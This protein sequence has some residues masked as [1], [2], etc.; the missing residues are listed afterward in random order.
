M[1]DSR[2]T[3]RTLLKSGVAATTA[4]GMVG[5]QGCRSLRTPGSRETEDEK[6]FLPLSGAEPEP[7]LEIARSWWPENPN[8]WTAVGWKDHPLQFNVLFNG[9][10]IGPDKILLFN[11]PY[12]GKDEDYIP[13]DDRTVVQGWNDCEAPV[14]WSRVFPYS[15]SARAYQGAQIQQEVFAHLKGASDIKTGQEPL[16]AWM[17]LSVADICEGFFL[18]NEENNFTFKIKIRGFNFSG[19]MTR[20]KKFAKA[21]P[22][23]LRPDREAYDPGSGWRLLEEDGKVFLGVASGQDCTV[24]YAPPGTRETDLNIQVKLR[25]GA[26]VDLLVPAELMERAVFDEELALGFEAALKGANAYWSKKPSTAARFDVPEEE[27]NQ[28]LRRHIQFAEI[29]AQ[30]H[31][32]SHHYMHLGCALSYNTL[33]PVTT[34]MLTAGLLLNPLG[35]HSVVEKYLQG[36]KAYQGKVTPVGNLFKP[37]PGYLN[38]PRT[39]TSYN[40]FSSHG[41]LLWVISDHAMLSGD[42]EIIDEWTPVVVKGCDWIQYALSIE[43][44]GGVS[45]IM[46]PGLG[47]DIGIVSQEVWNDTFMYKGLTTAIRFLRSI[48]HPRSQEFA[49]MARTYRETYQAAMRDRVRQ[50]PTWTGPDG[51]KR[52]VAPTCLSEKYSLTEIRNTFSLDVGALALV[53]GGL[54]DADDE[55]MENTRLWFREGPPKKFAIHDQQGFG[56]PCLDHETSSC[57][58]HWTWVMWHSRQLGDR[59]RYLESMY[60]VWMA[61]LSQQTYT[62]C[63]TRSGIF[64]LTP[65]CPSNALARFAVIDD[66][67]LDNELHLLRVM[68]L[69]WLSTDREAIFERMPTYYGPVDLRI[70]LVDSGKTLDVSFTSRFRKPPD[71]IVLHVPPVENLKAVRLNGRNLKWDRGQESL[72]IV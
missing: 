45:G 42:P 16:F 49:A 63:E 24:D 39:Q 28:I 69:A 5:L 70:Q 12:L 57:E 55:L 3:R 32:D 51:K 26:S 54:F 41:A 11:D 36:F 22:N 14:L 1:T 72:S 8:K 40:Y 37:H 18:D 35:Y 15:Y 50:M 27:V 62:L 52:H 67:I 17:R 71:K 2:L 64:G 7:N 58:A 30:K 46:P 21:Y 29:I 66:Q 13:L 48:G 23:P 53:W 47:S 31:D 44:P 10:L 6:A 61:E 4:A 34:I 38:E 19:G 56:I 68:P 20:I 65:Y 60:S 25:K 9:A 59:Q 33:G 43:V